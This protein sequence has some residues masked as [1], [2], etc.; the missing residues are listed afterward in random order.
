MNRTLSPTA[1][2]IL[3]AYAVG[4]G[5][6]ALLAVLFFGGQVVTSCL[7]FQCPPPSD[8]PI[9][10][11]GTAGGFRVTVAVLTAAWVFAL[12]AVSWSV[13]H[14]RRRRILGLLAPAGT[15][16]IALGVVAASI[17]LVSGARLRAVAS[18]GIT[19][20]VIVAV[21]VWIVAVSIAAWRSDP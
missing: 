9:P 1:R 7:S 14:E 4:L 17:Q 10:I 12:L 20:S 5:P 13:I 6:A 16:G 21:A 18:T 11:I 19:V 15:C 3:A 8:G 2:R